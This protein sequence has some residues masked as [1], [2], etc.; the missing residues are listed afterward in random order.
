MACEL[1]EEDETGT[2]LL[3]AVHSDYQNR[4]I[5][6]YLFARALQEMEAAGMKLV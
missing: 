1:D 6:A 4:G 3:L 5:G 2:I